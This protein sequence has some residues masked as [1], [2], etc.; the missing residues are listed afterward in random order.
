MIADIYITTYIHNY[1][2]IYIERERETET[3]TER[4]QV[5]VCS[6]IRNKVLSLGCREW[7]EEKGELTLGGW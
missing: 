5:S 7:A 4:G 6:S 3:E 2:Y 1:V